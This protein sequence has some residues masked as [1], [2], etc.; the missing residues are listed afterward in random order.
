MALSDHDIDLL[1][2]SMSTIR[3]RK[4]LATEIFY[5]RLFELDPALRKLFSE[6]IATQTEKVMV[7]LGAVLAQIHDLDLCREMT[8]DLA[9]RHVKYGVAAEDYATVGNAVMDMLAVLLDD[10]F[11]DELASAWRRAY[12]AI[13]ETMIASAYGT[14]HAA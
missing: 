6:D 10:Q 2:E 3:E 5:E 11:T 8:A 1:R 12:D 14:Q 9:V 4:H 13:A 7:A